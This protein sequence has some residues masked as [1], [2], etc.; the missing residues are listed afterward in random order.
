M[1]IY[2]LYSSA[3][4]KKTAGLATVL[5]SVLALTG[6]G[7]SGAGAPTRNIK[8][9]TDGVE[10]QSGSTLIRD[11]LLV[12]QPDGSAAL[13]GTFINEE[14]TANS[15]TGI[16]VG[17]IKA[18]LSADSFNLAQGVPVIFSGDSANATGVVAA[19]NTAAGN[20]VDVV[21]SFS[22]S[23][24]VTLSALVRAKSDYFASVGGAPVVSATPAPA[25]SK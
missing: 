12:S 19:L 16:T 4:M 25:A 5:V 10:A 8:Q 1:A 23:P 17:G 18:T 14:A 3:M 9:V 2:A 7:A 13:V 15:L 6:C 20:R 24:S 11:L 21:I 22:N